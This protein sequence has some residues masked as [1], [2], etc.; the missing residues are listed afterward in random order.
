MPG[1]DDEVIHLALV[2]RRNEGVGV[3]LAL[4]RSARELPGDL[5]GQVRSVE[6]RDAADSRSSGN[7]PLTV[8]R[9]ADAERRDH[10]ES[11][12]DDTSHEAV[13]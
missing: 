12:D 10:T 8:Q 2:L 7:Q 5:G 1:E 13:P 3:E 4:T 11:G 9:V 6:P